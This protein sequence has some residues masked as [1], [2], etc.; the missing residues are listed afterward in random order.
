MQF[1]DHL[2]ANCPPLDADF[3]IM[4]V[5]CLLSDP[6]TEKDFLSFWERN[7]NKVAD[8]ELICQSCGLSVFTDIIGAELAQKSS[9]SLRKKKLAKG[10][11]SKNSGKIKNTPSQ[12]TGDTHH[13][14][15]LNRDIDPC[16]LFKVLS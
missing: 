5:Y 12:N 15:W 13:T 16:S 8:P 10:H 2:P 9:R 4:V 14:W 1:R 7:S 6:P 3:S 11:L